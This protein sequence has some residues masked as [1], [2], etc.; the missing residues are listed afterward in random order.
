MFRILSMDGGGIRGTITA[1]I[2]TH[3]E[4][5]TGRPISDLF[6]LVVGTSTGSILAA[7]LTTPEGSGAPRY[8]AESILNLY[9]DRGQEI[10]SRSFWR[11]ITSLGGAVDEQYD[12]RPLERI[13]HELLGNATLADCIV[14]VV[15]TSY[16]IERRQ[17]YFL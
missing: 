10:F 3:I 12:H 5:E 8:A 11:G 15:I 6:D 9:A 13:L 4:Q 17:P 14:P 1:S 16:D 2:L 7:G